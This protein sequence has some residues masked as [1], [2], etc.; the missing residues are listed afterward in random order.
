MS[1]KNVIRIGDKVR[2]LDPRLFI[3]CGYPLCHKD[4]VDDLERNRSDDIQAVAKQFGIA[5]SGVVR[6]RLVSALAYGI[7]RSKRFGGHERS[8]HLTEP[9]DHLGGLVTTVADKAV[10]VTG[11]YFPPSGYY[12]DYDPGGLDGAKSHVILTLRAYDDDPADLDRIRSADSRIR[13]PASHVE[14]VT[15]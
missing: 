7:L 2:I 15:A 1:K 3:R 11:S 4:V 10:V 5:A 9:R 13:V 14:K 12:D 8:I 6:D